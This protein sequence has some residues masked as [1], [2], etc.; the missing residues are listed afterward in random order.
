MSAHLLTNHFTY[1]NTIGHNWMTTI[2]MSFETLVMPTSKIV[3]FYSLRQ[4][5]CKFG[6][7]WNV[8]L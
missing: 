4:H 7:F 8:M 3:N 5:P 6:A 2:N 1:N